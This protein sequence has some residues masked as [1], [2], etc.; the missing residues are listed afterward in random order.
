M[1]LA[2]ALGE[3]IWKYFCRHFPLYL[4]LILLFATG[5]GFG[6]IATQQLSPVQQADL[7][8]YLSD[9]YVSVAQ[10]DVNT[11]RGMVFYHSMV[12]NVLKTTGVL[13]LL[14]LTVIGA[15]LILG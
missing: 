6:A 4:A 9:I 12:D 3:L 11:D 10:K 13:F 2:G 15:P 5:L 1:F 8:N 14:G 7:T